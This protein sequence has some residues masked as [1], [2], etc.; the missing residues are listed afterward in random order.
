[1]ARG[2]WHDFGNN[3]YA[4]TA[5]SNIGAI[6]HE[7]NALLVD[8]GL[9]KDSARK[10]L[11]PIEAQKA[12]VTGILITHGH[13]DHFGGVAW[14]ARRANAPV[15]APSIE[16]AF[17]MHPLLEPLF[18]SGGA[19]PAKELTDKFTLARDAV[20]NV[21]PLYS[22][23]TSIGEVPVEIIDLPGHAPAQI[24]IATTCDDIIPRTLFCGD[25]VFPGQT[26]ARHPIPFCFDLDAW[27]E[28]L[29]TLSKSTFDTYVTGHGEPV[30]DIAPDATAT[31][32]RL[33]EIRD[34]V[35]AALV[36][37]QEPYNILRAVAKHFDTT[38][39]APQFFLLSL[40]TINATLTSLQRH[41]Q[42]HIIMENNHLLWRANG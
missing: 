11:R 23:V 37:P 13:A 9:D 26:L 17:A 24:G 20:E 2:T 38:F 10:A 4:L 14:A 18:L 27:L 3:T 6:I 39:S 40:T 32:S 16:G 5:G 19:A 28:T 30:T 31:A 33:E 21:R 22:G 12:R 7:G 36:R 25:A 41:A 29:A 15:Y 34:V 35:L 42:A 8:A 1:M